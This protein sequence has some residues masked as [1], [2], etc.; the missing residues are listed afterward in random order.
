[1]TPEGKFVTIN[2]KMGSKKNENKKLLDPC[3][4]DIIVWPSMLLIPLPQYKRIYGGPGVLMG[5]RKCILH[6]EWP[7]NFLF[8]LLVT[9]VSYR[10]EHQWLSSISGVTSLSGSSWGGQNPPESLQSWHAREKLGT[11]WQF[12]RTKVLTYGFLPFVNTSSLET[13]V[14]HWR[15]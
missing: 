11:L 12:G 8:R 4:N 2:P 1:M 10:S 9:L 3:T 6:M 15:W 14:L 13:P 5:P 7:G